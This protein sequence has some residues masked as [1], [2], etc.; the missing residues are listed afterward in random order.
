[1]EVSLDPTPLRPPLQPD[2]SIGRQVRRSG[3]KDTA[4]PFAPAP[5]ACGTFTYRHRDAAGR[6]GRI[7]LVEP[8][9]TAELPFDSDGFAKAE[10]IFPGDQVCND[11][12]FEGFR[13][14]GYDELQAVCCSLSGQGRPRCRQ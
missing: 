6:E 2:R 12:Q 5:F 11:R 14:L 9:L 8:A 3:A 7:L 10:A 1:V 4:E 13:R